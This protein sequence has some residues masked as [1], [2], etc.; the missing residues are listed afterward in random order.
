M[1]QKPRS[2]GYQESQKGFWELAENVVIK[3]LNI[4]YLSSLRVA[5]NYLGEGISFS[6]EI[7]LKNLWTWHQWE[8]QRM[9]VRHRAEKRLNE[10]MQWTV[11][12][13]VFSLLSPANIGCQLPSLPRKGSEEFPL[14]SLIVSIE[15]SHRYQWLYVF[16]KHYPSNDHKGNLP[17]HQLIMEIAYPIINLLSH[18]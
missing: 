11:R 5:N 18:F 3:Q 15:K 10:S 9:E 4:R 7:Q 2:W 13:L 1:L 12:L 14:C 6:G 17:I 8:E 16:P